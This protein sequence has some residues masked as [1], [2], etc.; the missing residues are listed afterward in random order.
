M[1]K[2]VVSLTRNYAVTIEAE[3][4]TDAKELAEYFVGGERDQSLQHEQDKYKFNIEEIEMTYNNACE[5][6]EYQGI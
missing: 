6:E 5:A 3:N 2:Y 4:E 1:R